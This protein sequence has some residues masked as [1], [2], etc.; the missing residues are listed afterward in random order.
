MKEESNGQIILEGFE[1]ITINQLVRAIEILTDMVPEFNDGDTA[2]FIEWRQQVRD[3]MIREGI[4]LDHLLAITPPG[5]ITGISL[6]RGDITIHVDGPNIALTEKEE[7]LSALT[8]LCNWILSD[9]LIAPTGNSLNGL[10]QDLLNKKFVPSINNSLLNNFVQMT[11]ASMKKDEFSGSAVYAAKDGHKLEVTNFSDVL[12]TL[13]VSANKLFLYAVY[14]LFQ[15]NYYRSNPNSVIP[16]IEMPLDEY[17]K[18]TKADIFPRIMQTSDEQERENKRTAA[19]L[20]K[21]KKDIKRDFNDI[22]TLEWTAKETKGPIAGDY[23]KIRLISSHGITK[24]KITVNFDFHIAVYLLNSYISQFPTVLF[25]YDN[26]K[27]NAFAIAYKIAVHNSMDNNYA[28]GTNNTLGVASLL[29]AAP[30]IPTKEKLQKTNQRNWKK[31]IKGTLESALNESITMGFLSKWEYR[32]PKTGK[33]YTPSQANALTYLKWH[34]LMV[35]F[36]VIDAPD[37]T[38]RR[39]ARAEAKRLAA[40]A[41]TETPAKRP[42][43]R[44]KKK[45]EN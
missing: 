3:R 32:E 24:G 40:E 13:G 35:D 44:P 34:S 16:S 38:E 8:F 30:E 20:K 7:A 19:N 18:L 17:A 6:D 2:S 31:K 26:R 41:K 11:K 5:K 10:S 37:Q 23:K 9:N 21:L 45:P 22:A 42:R 4:D 39:A 27:P 33:I 15:T 1:P 36:I 29:A 14:Y 43:G 25:A 12:G 28:I